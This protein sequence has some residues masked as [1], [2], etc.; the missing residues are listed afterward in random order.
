[1]GK[2]PGFYRTTI[3]VPRD[4]KRRMDAAKE[5]INWSAIACRAFEEKLA[6]IATKKEEKTM[7][8]IIQRL[9]ATKPDLIYQQGLADGRRWASEQAEYEDLLRLERFYEKKRSGRDW[10]KFFDRDYGLPTWEQIRESFSKENQGKSVHDPMWASVDDYV[11]DVSIG[12]RLMRTICPRLDAGDFGRG[13]IHFDR[14]AWRSVCR[15]FWKS[16]IGDDDFKVDN[17]SYVRGFAEGAL[18]LWREVQDKL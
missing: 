14:D 7:A 3:S 4:L 13:D 2:K 10:E 5:P 17:P 11:N 9:R 6:E 8:D 18:A 1:M 15:H 16:Y 12:E